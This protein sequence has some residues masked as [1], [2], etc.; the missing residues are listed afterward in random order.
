MLGTG[1]KLVVSTV[2]D[3][4]ARHTCPKF[5]IHLMFYAPAFALATTDFNAARF[6]IFSGWL[7]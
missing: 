2:F 1:E 4:T 3:A 5:E 7:C 6:L